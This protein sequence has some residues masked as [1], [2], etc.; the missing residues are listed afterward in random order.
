MARTLPKT[1]M[2]ACAEAGAPTHL[3]ERS[4]EMKRLPIVCACVASSLVLGIVLA[5]ASSADAT[6]GQLGVF[7]RQGL[8]LER[9]QAALATQSQVEAAK[10]PAKLEEAL[11]ASFAGVWFEPNTAK[12]G[13]GVVSGESRRVAEQVVAQA[14]LAGVVNYV[15]VRSTWVQLIRAQ[16][17][18]N[19]KLGHLAGQQFSTG[20]SAS[21]N[22]VSVTISSSVPAHE[23]ALL[24]REAARFHVNVSIA[25]VPPDALEARP[26]NS[27]CEI[28]PREAYA[29]CSKPIAGGVLI[30]PNVERNGY[31]TAGP[32]ALLANPATL[33]AALETF[34]LTAGHCL[35]GKEKWF[36]ATHPGNEL[37]EI[38]P[39]WKFLNDLLG[40]YGAIEVG[41]NW[42]QAGVTPALAQITHYQDNGLREAQSVLGEAASVEGGSFCKQGATSAE[43]CGSIKHTNLLVIFLEEPPDVLSHVD[44]LVETNACS[45]PG[46]S[47]GPYA[48]LPNANGVD[49]LGTHVGG[50]NGKCA[51]ILFCETCISYYE[52]IQTSLTGLGLSLLTTANQTRHLTG[53]SWDVNGTPLV[54]AAALAGTIKV[55]E[56]GSLIVHIAGVRIECLSQ[57]LGIEGGEIVAPDEVRAKSLEFK[58]CAAT[59]GPCTLQ[60]TVIKTLA[61]HG[62]AELDGALG[63]LIKILPL[64]SKTFAAVNFLGTTCALA[65]VQPVTGTVDL[66]AP[67]G[68]DPAI[69][70]L[71]RVF[72]LPGS[73]KVGS[74]EALLTGLEGDVQ[75]ASG[76]PW[77]FL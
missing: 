38:G 13:I 18:W 16:G 69:L 14:G 49:I 68:K 48:T 59:E 56:H 28:K 77:N 58:E 34:I 44:G 11:G 75:L 46:D 39:T 27:Q 21:H 12:F 22:A 7:T 67:S 42:L 25:V 8:S 23:R 9:A 57:E 20:L 70:Q 1:S 15:S 76:Q 30:T 61:L 33:A 52:P 74:D 3:T 50:P 54:G 32:L 4:N 63:T 31:C 19:A 64:P 73:L 10:L 45:E 65:G 60:E 5:L 53:G 66:L 62:L 35:E 2:V 17:E 6:S 47:G 43:Q 29:F 51:G 41:P 55:L 72:S 71:V 24:E 36:T 40:D 37:K 26:H